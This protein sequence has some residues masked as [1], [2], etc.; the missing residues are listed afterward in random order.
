MKKVFIIMLILVVVAIISFFVFQNT[1]GWKTYK[2]SRYN[3]SVEYPSNWSLNN[4]PANN[5]GREFVSPDGN[6]TCHAYGFANSLLNSKG[7]PQTLKEFIDWLIDI[8]TEVKTRKDVVW[9][10]RKA[11]ELKMVM[12]GT[13]TMA[14]YTLNRKEGLGLACYYSDLK[15][16]EKLSNQYIHIKTSFKLNSEKVKTGTISCANLLNGSMTPFKDLQTFSDKNYTE[17]TIISRNAWN[18]IK[19]PKQVTS[20][21]AKG[22]TCYPM[23]TEFSSDESSG[24]VSAQPEVT[25]VQWSCELKYTDWQYIKTGDNPVKNA[26][27]LS[28]LTCQQQTCLNSSMKDDAVWLCTGTRKIDPKTCLHPNGDVENWWNTATKAEKNCFIIK[29]PRSPFLAQ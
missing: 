5:D 17:V 12:N 29:Y 6:I 7:E 19:L 10:G 8:K 20:L 18:K 16:L 11:A 13:P 22:Y 1:K 3:F 27:E 28:G 9:G 24:G 15:T 14:V 26:T 23:P 25:K 21:Q 2:N 4:A